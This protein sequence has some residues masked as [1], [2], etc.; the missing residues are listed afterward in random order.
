[1]KFKKIAAV[2][3]AAAVMLA[4][5][6]CGNEEKTSKSGGNITES[7]IESVLGNEINSKKPTESKAPEKIT[8]APTD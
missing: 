2:V 6:G 8:L 4:L 7:R 5:A 3:S 1:M